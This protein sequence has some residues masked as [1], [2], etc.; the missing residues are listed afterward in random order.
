MSL[1]VLSSMVMKHQ[2]TGSLLCVWVE[3][4]GLWASTHWAGA[5]QRLQLRWMAL[6]WVVLI[7]LLLVLMFVFG[8]YAG[9]GWY[10][11]PTWGVLFWAGSNGLAQVQAVQ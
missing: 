10:G 4:L 1:P 11:G 3:P 2:P 5:E 9:W 7:V 6:S 8:E